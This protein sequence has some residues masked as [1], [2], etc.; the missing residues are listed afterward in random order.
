MTANHSKSE[1]C[2]SSIDDKRAML[3][4]ARLRF[5]PTG[6]NIREQA[7]ERIVEQHLAYA[8]SEG[9][10]LRGL[11][12]AIASAEG[13]PILSLPEVE[14]ALKRLVS[15]GRVRKKKDLFS[16]AEKALADVENQIQ[17]SMTNWESVLKSLFS[18]A[19]KGPDAYA[20]AF[21]DTLCNIFSC[22]SASDIAVLTGR[23]SGR[24][25]ANHLIEKG[26][27]SALSKCGVPDDDAFKYGVNRFFE[28]SNPSFDA[29]K[30][31]MAQNHFV[32]AALGIAPASRLLSDDLLRG[33]TLFLDT[34]VLIA[35]LVPESKNHGAFREVV[36]ACK[37]L[38]IEVKVAH[39]T[40]EELR[41]TVFANAS[42]LRRAYSVIPAETLP[43]VRCFLLDAYRDALETDPSLGIDDFLDNFN[44][45]MDRIREVLDVEVEDDRWFDQEADSPETRK[46]AKSLA[47]KVKEMRHKNKT[48]TAAVHDALLIRWIDQRRAIGESDARVATLD[49]T[50]VATDREETETHPRTITLDALLLWAEPHCISTEKAAEHVAAVYASALRY[51]LLPAGQFLEARDFL[52]FADMEIET[53]QLPA[54]D[55]EACVREIHLLGPNLDPGKA[56]D[57]EKI[58]RTIQGYFA[59][60]GAKFRK[61]MANLNAANRKL[62]E[63]L[64]A[65]Q[66]AREVAEKTLSQVQEELGK[67]RNAQEQTQTAL[68]REVSAREATST[69]LDEV[70]RQ[71]DR[72]LRSAERDRLTRS[73]MRRFVFLGVLLLLGWGYVGWWALRDGT[74]DNAFQKLTNAWGWFGCVTAIV[75]GLLYF[76]MG[77]ERMKHIKWWKGDD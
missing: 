26:I 16:L 14:G 48:E 56:E 76:V 41:R 42:V 54:S 34:N 7:V 44:H 49:L 6:A 66:K 4:N 51:Q 25:G 36:G 9:I 19:P 67:T 40:V 37:H 46:L 62:G 69:E 31:N 3:L 71:T 47:S 52:V 11:H 15:T 2:P 68:E 75:A 13:V 43:K 50:L 28:E 24:E 73:V 30:W 39:I 21:T 64:D 17:Q 45:P 27:E 12:A 23:E 58:G 29:I 22:L 70:R 61:E 55:V 5:S 8:T 57:R 53:S 72:L 33:T 20:V 38:G 65:E 18:G 59:D 63:Q 77:R 74:G 10:Q 35:G 60:P 1:K 32:I